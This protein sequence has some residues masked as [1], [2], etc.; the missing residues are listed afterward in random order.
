MSVFFIYRIFILPL[1]LSR[2]ATRS[3]LTQVGN[4]SQPHDVAVYCSASTPAISPPYA[5]RASVD[6]SSTALPGR[7]APPWPRSSSTCGGRTVAAPPRSPDYRHMH[8]LPPSAVARRPAGDHVPLAFTSL[9]VAAFGAGALPSF[10]RLRLSSTA[11][12]PWRTRRRWRERKQRENREHGGTRL[13]G[14]ACYRISLW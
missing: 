6:R 14:N 7:Y 5:L 12:H 8:V 4:F 11:A 1:N 3:S 10:Q 13:L 9:A 2:K